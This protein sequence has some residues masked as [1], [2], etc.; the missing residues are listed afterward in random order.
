MTE[1]GIRVVVIVVILGV[2]LAAAAIAGRSRRA[3]PVGTTRDDL[4]PGVHL[5][6]SATCA[7]CLEA[8]KVVASVYG[9]AFTETRH[10]VDPQSF[11]HHAIVRVP[12]LIVVL[13]DSSALVFEGLPRRRHL[14]VIPPESI[15]SR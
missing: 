3:R 13:A 2:I 8:R 6:T 1:T 15:A 14:P 5:F 10:E 4:P 9:D 11:G 12:T 7:T